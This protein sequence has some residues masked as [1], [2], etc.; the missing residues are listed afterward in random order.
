MR[1][2]ILSTLFLLC[3]SVLLSG[4]TTTRT[5]QSFP[6]TC[7]GEWTGT[8]EIFAG[9]NRK[10]Q[11]ELSIRLDAPD[12]LGYLNYT[13]VYFG[14]DKVERRPYT[15]K[16]HQRP[17]Y[18]YI[19]ENNG[20][21]LQAR[22]MDRTLTSIFKIKDQVLLSQWTCQGDTSH[23]EI[24]VYPDLWEPVGETE[25]EEITASWPLST[26]SAVLQRVR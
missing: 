22:V 6:E 20:T 4:Q 19:D 26:Q 17:G 8:L 14:E 25:G 5:G 11:I 13:L 16:P 10:S 12:S 1:N 3:S 18:W 21:V 23:W 15:L 2:S 9:Q 7:I 24:L